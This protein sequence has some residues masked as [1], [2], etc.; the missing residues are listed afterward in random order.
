M[1]NKEKRYNCPAT[2]LEVLELEEF[3]NIDFGNGYYFSVKKIGDSIIYTNNRGNMKNSN[4]TRYYKMIEEFA[5]S[6]HIKKPFVEIRDYKDLKGRPTPSQKDIQK[7]YFSEHK[8]DYVRAIICNIPDWLS[9]ILRMMPRLVNTSVKKIIVCKDY[10]DAVQ[11]AVNILQSN[12]LYEK[13]SFE[14]I[15]IKPEWCFDDNDF[16]LINGVIPQKLFYTSFE[17][18]SQE[19]TPIKVS[20]CMNKLFEEGTLTNSSYI[21]VADYSKLSN[22]PVK[23]R[24]F[25]AELLNNLNKKYN[26]NPEKSF[27]CG[28]SGSVKVAI[29][30]YAFIVKQ[31]FIFVD[32]VEEAFQAIN[33][34]K[35]PSDKK[36]RVIKV[37]KK[38]IE[39]I[40]NLSGSL[41][42]NETT[43]ANISV[44]KT[45]PLHQLAATLSL[46]QDDL[47]DL[48]KKEIEQTAELQKSLE[49]LEN[50]TT[51]LRDSNEETL[52][53]NEELTTTNEQLS[54]QKKELETAQDQLLEM[55]TSLE[56]RVKRRTGKLKKTVKQLNKTVAELD[57]FVYSASHDLSA[58]L[59]SILGLLNIA[60]IDPDKN[61]IKEYLDYIENN[62][63]KLEDVIKSLI[64]YSRNSRIKVKKENFN[65]YDLVNDVIRELAFL[66][67]V[68]S[69]EFI[70]EVS[71]SQ[72]IVSDKQRL[73]VIL[74]NLINNSVKYIDTTKLQPKVVIGF[75]V[76]DGRYKIYVKDNGPGIEK[77]QIEKIF[78]MFYRGTEKSKGSGLGL[79]IVKETIMALDGKI[80][81][82]S[83]PGEETKFRMYLPVLDN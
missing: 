56:K 76:V 81:V 75:E 6:T 1:E 21:R 52:Q 47:I 48:R 29:R 65:L 13:I 49:T 9:I 24:N 45:N 43:K 18:I 22:V 71:P 74:H 59:K 44:S 17:G 12:S 31:K 15:T 69:I 46:I 70:V 83:I 30:L 23:T 11:K 63:Y 80:Q 37:N 62:I 82:D 60:K 68:D 32:N 28:A 79:F 39:E 78:N 73:R 27:V 19:I 38:D 36:E 4:V 8:D 26:C 66:P 58:P 55:N 10:S 61:N 33:S 5:E 20:E 40:I 34:G 41:I 2:G 57:R 53:L 51:K 25:Y 72:T 67:S 3:T 16:K 54:T 50:L 14:D 42:W 77:N 64:S 7:K 35:L